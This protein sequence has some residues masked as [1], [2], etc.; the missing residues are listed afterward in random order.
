MIR[1]FLLIAFVLVALQGSAQQ[2]LWN[3]PQLKQTPSYHWLN[4]DTTKVRELIFNGQAYDKFPR[5]QVFAYYATPGTLSGDKSKDHD[6]P[7]IVLIHGGGG[8]AFK[9]WVTQWA[10]RGYAAISMDLSGN[11]VDA[12]ALPE[13]GPSQDPV[14][15]FTSIDSTTDKQWVYHSVC[16]VILAHSLILSFKEV[17]TAKTA[18]TGISWGGF[19]TCIVAG[20]DDRFKAAVPVYGCGFIYKPG[21][22]FYAKDFGTMTM[23]QKKKWADRYD[24]SHYIGKAK[25]PFLWVTGTDDPFYPPDCLSSTYNLVR[26]YSSYRIT[27]AM[28]HGHPQ[29]CAPKEIGEFVDQNLFHSIPLP[30]IKSVRSDGRRV[31]ARIRSKLKLTAASISYT[32]DTV[33][34]YSS[35][36][37]HT[38]E[39]LLKNGKLVAPP[40]PPATTVWLINVTDSGG[41]T[42]SSSYFFTSGT[43]KEE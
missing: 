33:L 16:N 26:K 35:R 19:L 29:G 14:V 36:R 5:T 3:I 25:I 42:I 20:L 15:K 17:D 9:E 30:F 8:Y 28:T 27:T 41:S 18:V 31:K 40:L 1:S 39:T 21:G 34:P 22:Y 24:P 10:N 2:Q 43:K 32:T 7:A 11:G 23:E 12:K 6:L 13:G 37:W 4:S 38:I